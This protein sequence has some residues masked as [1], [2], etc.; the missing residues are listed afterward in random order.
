M[1][2]LIRKIVL[3][4]G[5]AEAEIAAEGGK[6]HLRLDAALNMPVERHQVL[7]LLDGVLEAMLHGDV[8]P[9]QVEA[10]IKRVLKPLSRGARMSAYF[11]DK[12]Q[13]G[14]CIRHCDKKAVKGQKLCSKHL[15]ETRKRMAERR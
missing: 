3:V 9:A 8:P 11:A 15:R 6:L 7:A 4:A 14:E 5:D 10:T 1:T 12:N 2:T 13:R